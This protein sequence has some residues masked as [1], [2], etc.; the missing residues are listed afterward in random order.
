M[1]K[2]NSSP[3]NGDKDVGTN[4]RRS[5]K[6]NSVKTVKSDSGGK[7]SGAS[8]NYTNMIAINGSFNVP[9]NEHRRTRRSSSMEVLVGSDDEEAE[10]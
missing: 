4:S 5:S 3:S 7:A 8:N 10:K 9:M 6:T 1:A 2:T